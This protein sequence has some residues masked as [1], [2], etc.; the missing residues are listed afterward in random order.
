[1][2]Q[3]GAVPIFVQ[4]LSSG[5][6]R[7]REQAVWALGNIAGDGPN[8]RN[9]VLNNKALEPLLMRLHEATSQ[10]MIRNSTWTLSNLCRGKPQPDFQKV[11][12]ALP[13]IASLIRNDDQEVI[14]DACW[15]LSY[16]SDGDAEQVG[17]RLHLFNCVTFPPVSRWLY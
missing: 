11:R 12:P 8:C 14:V 17:R 4:L 16:L 7:V 9:I 6:E 3:Y 1:M 15:A 5:S 13:I 10:S 2:I